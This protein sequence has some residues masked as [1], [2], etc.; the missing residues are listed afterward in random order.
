M[1][2]LV[3]LLQVLLVVSCWDFSTLVTRIQ[4][5]SGDYFMRVL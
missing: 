5:L 1:L 2:Q 4:I 3:C